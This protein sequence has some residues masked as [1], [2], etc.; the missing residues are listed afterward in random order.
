MEQ[1]TET[2]TTPETTIELTITLSRTMDTLR[3]IVDE[4]EE[5]TLSRLADLG[6]IESEEWN[7][8]EII[9]VD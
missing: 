7:W 2:G 9:P 3:A 1:T 5:V 4:P 6:D 8:E